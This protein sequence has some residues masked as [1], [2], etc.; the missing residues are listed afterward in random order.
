MRHVS[1]VYIRLIAKQTLSWLPVDIAARTVTDLLLRPKAPGLVAHVE[2]PVRQSWTDVCSV[3]E[4][5][6][7]IPPRSRLPYS[8]W[9]DK[10]S[11]LDRSPSDLM[12]F[13]EHDFQQ[14][15]GG[16]VILDTKECRER[17]PTLR[18]AG[19]IGPDLVGLYLS[20]WR[21]YGFLED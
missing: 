5:H 10:V 18:S 20:S 8:E 17:S 21:R 9:L 4:Y 2:N 14:M 3:L 12:G 11:K 16:S 6:L 7:G 19:A 13:F 15:A 1:Y